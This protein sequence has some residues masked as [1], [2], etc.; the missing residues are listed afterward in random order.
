MLGREKEWEEGNG[1]LREMWS[2]SDRPRPGEK[3]GERKDK[4]HAQHFRFQLRAETRDVVKPSTFAVTGPLSR[5]LTLCKSPELG[6]N[7]R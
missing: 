3:E 2:S 1:A 5:F 4:A 7:L 6:T